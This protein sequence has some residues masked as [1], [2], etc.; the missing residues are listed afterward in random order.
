M[1]GKEWLSKVIRPK[2]SSQLT[3]DIK[4]TLLN[5]ITTPSIFRHQ[6]LRCFE[7]N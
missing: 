1:L 2:A 7:L 3:P 4:L 5:S 6:K